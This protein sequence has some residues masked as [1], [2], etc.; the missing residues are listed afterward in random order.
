[1]SNV[2]REENYV[3]EGFLVGTTEGVESLGR[4]VLVD[5]NS[6]GMGLVVA[7]QNHK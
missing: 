4:D 3:W 2:D 7:T 1:M 5:W 6:N